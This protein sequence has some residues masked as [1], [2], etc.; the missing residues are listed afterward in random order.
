M[1]FLVAAFLGG[2]VL[3]VQGYRALTHEEVAATVRTEPVGP[4]KFRADFRFTDG[5]QVSYTLNGDEL[6]VDAR[7]LKW[8]PFANIFGLHT[9]YELDRVAG[10]YLDIEEE[11]R[12]ARTVHSLALEREVDLFALR[13]RYALMS[14]LLDAEYGSGTFV[15]ADAP[16][17]YEVR[18]S[19]TGLLM[20][21]VGQ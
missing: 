21:R 19:T 6:Y 12:Q 13:K 7:V 16:A 5:R 15:P 1:F 3:G 8:Q 9:V 11:K 2:I 18:V 14:P 17:Q 20:R 10:R 4:K